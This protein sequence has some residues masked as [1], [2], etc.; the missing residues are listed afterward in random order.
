MSVDL[1]IVAHY[2]R[3]QS[4]LQLSVF[5]VAD[6]HAQ[7]HL[8][9]EGHVEL[10]NNGKRIAQRI[11][12]TG[13]HGTGSSDTAAKTETA[14]AIRCLVTCRAAD[15]V[16]LTYQVV[17]HLRDGVQLEQRGQVELLPEG[18]AAHVVVFPHQPTTRE[19]SG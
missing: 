14:G 9:K 18:V 2:L 6:D 11:D 3:P 13:Y 10:Y 1:R 19:P 12:F 17:A 15:V 8:V 5:V 16:A 7:P 4:V